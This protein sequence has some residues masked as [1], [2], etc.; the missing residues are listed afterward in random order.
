M[1]KQITLFAM[2]MVCA[3]VSLSGCKKDKDVDLTG[4]HTTAAETTPVAETMA[5]ET[6]AAIVIQTE[7]ETT[8]AVVFKTIADPYVGKMSMFR[9]YSG[10]IKA[11]STLFNPNKSE[12]ER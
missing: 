2:L 10:E 6:T 3:A 7:A 5:Q 12:N 9:V 1:R 11:D 4:I 8:A